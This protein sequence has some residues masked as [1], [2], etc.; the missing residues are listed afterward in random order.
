[1]DTVIGL[2]VTMDTCPIQGIDI[3]NLKL[4]DVEDILI[5]VYV[6]EMAEMGYTRDEALYLARM[7]DLTRAQQMV[8]DYF[9][10]PTGIYVSEMKQAKQDFQ[11]YLTS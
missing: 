7:R 9:G 1:M 2:P 10:K 4:I 8:D 3:N 11:I 5:Q 6:P